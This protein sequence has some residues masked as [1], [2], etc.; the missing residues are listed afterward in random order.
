MTRLFSIVLT[1]WMLIP[2]LAE[3]AELKLWHAYRGAEAEA[4]EEAAKV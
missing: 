4:L 1:L 3:A 2:S